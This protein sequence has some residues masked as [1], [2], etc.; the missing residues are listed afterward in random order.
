M[1]LQAKMTVQNPIFSPH[2]DS[3][4]YPLDHREGRKPRVPRCCFQG[5]G[6]TA[7]GTNQLLMVCFLLITTVEQIWNTG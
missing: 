4:L 7:S 5:G 3:I 6:S 1:N 2:S